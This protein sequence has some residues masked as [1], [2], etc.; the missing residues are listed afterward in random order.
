MP[1]EALIFDRVL[2][3][4]DTGQAGG[5]EIRTVGASG[6]AAGGGGGDTRFPV[7]EG[8]HGGSNNIGRL[9]GTEDTG[10]TDAAGAGIDVEIAI[11]FGVF[12]LRILE[13]S[14]VLFDIG[15]RAEQ[16]L[17]FARPKSNPYCA[18]RLQPQRLNN[19]SGFEHHGRTDGI[20]G[21]AGG[22]VPGIEMSA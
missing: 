20:V 3:Q 14:E 6:G 17:F 12:G 11:Q 10:A 16:A 7:L 8:L 15:G 4:A 18:A 21:G 22:G 1:G 13:S 5:V 19:A 2:L 9:G